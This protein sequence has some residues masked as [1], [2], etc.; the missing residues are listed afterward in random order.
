M[1][2]T[3]TL[4]PARSVRLD[5]T[6]PAT[7]ASLTLARTGP[8]G[9]PASVR[10][11]ENAPVVAGAVIARDF[12]API[13]V[14]L[15]YTA[16]TRNAGGTVIDTATVAITITSQ[17]CEDTWLNDLARTTNT[18]QVLLEALPELA[19][20]VPASTHEIIS[21]RAPIITSDVALTPAFELSFLT[22]TLDD[23]DRARAAL[24]NGIPVLLRTPPETGV[25]NLYFSVTDFREQRI[26]T[27]GVVADRRFVVS[28]R[29]VQRPDPALYAPAGPA[30]YATI[31]AAFATYTA[32]KAGRPNYDA[33][34]YNWSGS[35]PADVVP[36]PP[37]DV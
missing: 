36:W 8:S 7:G 31:K 4:E 23:R 22:A 20:P 12:E 13:G 25:G 35:G 17:G 3:A 37:V 24:G 9:T 32:L 27:Q 15:T 2:L 26:V 28:G 21:R 33:V 14:P 16:T 10:S 19:Y 6:V 29:Q 5:Y 18:M 30:I 34:L 11:W 1:A